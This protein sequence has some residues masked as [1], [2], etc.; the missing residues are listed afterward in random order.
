MGLIDKGN[1]SDII[2]TSINQI[3]LALEY[4]RANGIFRKAIDII[5]EYAACTPP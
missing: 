1:E 5:K 3:P 4:F 2:N